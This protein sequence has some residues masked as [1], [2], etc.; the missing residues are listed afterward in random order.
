[1]HAHRMI[2]VKVAVFVTIASW[3]VA[4]RAFCFAPQLK[5]SDEYFTS[6]LVVVAEVISSKDRYDSQDRESIEGTFYRLRVDHAYRGTPNRELNVFSENTTAR[7]SMDLN[8][9]YVLFLTR[10]SQG[11]WTV[12]NCG[13]S[14]VVSKSAGVMHALLSL[15]L[16][17]SFVYGDVY[18]W[19]PNAKPCTNMTLELFGPSDY[20]VPVRNDC[21]FRTNVLP[22]NYRARM[23]ASGVQVLA[24]DLIYKDPYCFTVPSGGSAGL[25]FRAT[26][27][28]DQVNLD[29]VKLDDAFARAR[30]KNGPQNEPRLR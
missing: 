13:N 7:F 21:S 23:M 1:M 17:H 28:A 6:S 5:V 27:G 12:D 15:P 16:A 19:W 2:I 25:A 30:C 29:M 22:G 26:E 11:N 8:Q 24:N 20:R 18:H 3:G 9:N 14:G 10:D 4:A